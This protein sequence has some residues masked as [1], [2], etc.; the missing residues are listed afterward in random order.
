MSFKS[1]PSLHTENVT[2]IGG[3]DAE[4]RANRTSLE[5]YYIG[6]KVVASTMSK[7]G[8]SNIHVFQTEVGNTGV[9]GKANLD[10]QLQAVKP[11]TMTRITFTGMIKPSKA[12]RKPAYGYKV[13]VDEENTITVGSGTNSAATQEDDLSD[14]DYA[15]ADLDT[16]DTAVDEQAYSHPVR[17]AQAATAPSAEAQARVRAQLGRK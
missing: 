13:E 8:K 3:K 10:P 7:S 9:W 16:E 1:L 12:G 11:G 2:A 14:A 5:G 17:P 15:D 6:A 4:G